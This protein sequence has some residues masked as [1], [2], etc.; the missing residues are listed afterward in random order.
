MGANLDALCVL[1]VDSAGECVVAHCLQTCLW[2]D[3]YTDV[4]FLA[5]LMGT[6]GP[7]ETYR[8]S[9]VY[10]SKLLA[11]VGSR[12]CVNS[13]YFGEM[14]YLVGGRVLPLHCCHGKRTLWEDYAVCAGLA[15][16]ENSQNLTVNVDKAHRFCGHQK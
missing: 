13:E 8:H 2:E 10:I 15:A 4:P 9:V 3:P 16:G 5:A 11:N 14:L 12:S 6:A 7:G 1:F